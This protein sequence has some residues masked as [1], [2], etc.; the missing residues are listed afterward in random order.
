YK[1]PPF[2]I[3]NN[4]VSDFWIREKRGKKRQKDFNM[5]INVIENKNLS[6]YKEF[7]DLVQ[8][9]YNFSIE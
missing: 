4:V 5:N 1:V 8:N 3:H 7:F 9:N 6:L 2:T